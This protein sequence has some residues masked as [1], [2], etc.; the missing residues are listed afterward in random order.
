MGIYSNAEDD[1][2]IFMK[3]IIGAKRIGNINL[4][5]HVY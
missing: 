1:S 4:L 3:Q 5:F 2:V